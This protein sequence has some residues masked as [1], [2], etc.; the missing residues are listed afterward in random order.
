MSEISMIANNAYSAA[1]VQETINTVP[2]SVQESNDFQKIMSANLNKF[3][4]MSPEKILTYINNIK[5]GNVTNGVESNSVV[6]QL[7]CQ[8]SNQLKR[9]EDTIRKSLIDEASL[10]EL[11]STTAAAQNEVKTLVTLRDKFV[12]AWDKVMNMQI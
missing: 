8:A 5:Y 1:N 12:E 3:S 6:S 9:H 11:L 2:K 7:V 4:K 10:N